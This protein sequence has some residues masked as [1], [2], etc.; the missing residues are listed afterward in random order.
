M[1]NH[2][3]SIDEK[4]DKRKIINHLFY[5]PLPYLTELCLRTVAYN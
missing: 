1:I 2:K 5:L 3:K 4:R